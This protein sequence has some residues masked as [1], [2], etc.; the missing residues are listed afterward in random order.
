MVLLV[1][2]AVVLWYFVGLGERFDNA[3]GDVMQRAQG[4]RENSGNVIFLRV[5][6][7]S[8]KRLGPLPWKPETTKELMAA[9]ETQHPVKVIVA[10][11]PAL[12]FQQAETLN[13]PWLMVP[14]IHEGKASADVT[15]GAQ[16]SVADPDGIYRSLYAKHPE[17]SLPGQAWQ[18]AATR[19]MPDGEKV[20]VNFAGPPNSLTNLSIADLITG[21]APNDFLRGRYAV[22][23][24][25]LPDF[26]QYL[27]TPV[28]ADFEQM[29]E[30][31]FQANALLTV[32]ENNG[33]GF[34][35][36]P[37]AAGLVIAVVLLFWLASMPTSL[38]A[39]Q[40]LTLTTIVIVHG[41]GFVVFYFLHILIPVS[42]LDLAV[43]LTFL[44]SS[45]RK[46]RRIEWQT[47][48][49]AS[50]FS[51][52]LTLHPSP[53][54]NQEKDLEASWERLT[55]FAVSYLNPESMALAL[56]DQKGGRIRF[57][58]FHG[59][60]EGEIKEL[61]R[62]LSRQPYSSVIGQAAAEQVERYMKNPG[63]ATYLV[64][65]NYP[66]EFQGLWVVNFEAHGPE[67][68]GR[69]ATLTMVG[70]QLARL[71][72]L[73]QDLREKNRTMLMFGSTVDRMQR[74]L[75]KIR[76]VF[77]NFVE[78]KL[79]LYSVLDH[80]TEG[81][82]LTDM[83]G[84]ILHVNEPMKHLFA[85]M[86]IRVEELGELAE[87]LRRLEAPEN[88][89]EGAWLLRLHEEPESNLFS[90]RS[91]QFLLKVLVRSSENMR[92]PEGYLLL[93]VGN[94]KAIAAP[95]QVSVSEESRGSFSA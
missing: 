47:R 41:A 69:K 70:Q 36:L 10:A 79:I 27:V 25:D 89:Q 74:Q 26:T 12:I 76:Q 11:N 42:G 59:M 93:A 14:Q 88:I 38:R 66:S 49:L 19:S 90:A 73:G 75:K 24:F 80:L 23:G 31:E 65:L 64:P 53:G 48:D 40:I 63:L 45:N 13:Y 83:F 37:C 2:L 18:Y 62:D 87:L 7:P 46:G 86:G 55:K 56:P 29:S 6:A 43:I 81:M 78:E 44:A 33:I 68:Q 57:T 50:L 91:R 4:T 84:R 9:L 28:N 77:S 30:A 52:E 94:G 39:H 67:P 22:I 8:L 5:D 54:Q 60:E 71:I 15:N 85:E 21:A 3:F 16:F 82:V 35:P 95:S 34:C 32:V 51:W 58:F 72:V 17:G 1:F 92:I 61:R 20:R